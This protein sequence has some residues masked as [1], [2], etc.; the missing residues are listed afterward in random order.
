[1]LYDQVTKRCK[2]PLLVGYTLCK[3]YIVIIE[4]GQLHSTKKVCTQQLV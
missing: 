4:I 1:M 2:H 3:P